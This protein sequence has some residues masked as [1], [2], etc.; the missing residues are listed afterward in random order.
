M[1]LSVITIFPDVFSAYFRQGVIGRAL[2][3]GLFKADVLDLRDFTTDKHKTVDDTPYGGGPGMVMK[4]EPLASAIEHAKS[5]P[6]ETLTIMLSPQ[7]GLFTQKKAERLASEQRK[8]ILICGRY[9]GIDQ[10]VIDTMVDEEMSIG[11]YVL[12]GGELAALVII[13]ASVRLVPGVVGDEGSLVS[14]SFSWGM[15]DY[16]HYTRP[17]NWRGIGVP[18]VLIGGHHAMINRFRRKEALRKTLTRRP[19]MLSDRALLNEEDK[20]L[21][22]E[23]EEEMHGHDKGD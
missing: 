18:D 10:R 3:K 17:Q 20:I 5:G 2:D 11:D 22:K 19:E 9:E 15:L 7:G 4:P 12:T 16:P 23:I 14:E 8:I 13:D 1:Q 21:L 6:D